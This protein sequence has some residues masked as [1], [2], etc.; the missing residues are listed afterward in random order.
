MLL[1]HFSNAPSTLPP[2]YAPP[3]RY[4]FLPCS[5]SPGESV[6]K[7]LLEGVRLPHSQA[8][9]GDIE[10]THEE[11]EERVW[12]AFSPCLYP[13]RTG[14]RGFMGKCFLMCQELVPILVNVKGVCE[15]K[16]VRRGAQARRRE[17]PRPTS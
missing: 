14:G 1:H 6:I 4:T 7:F 2:S 13:Y 15:R 17:E 9:S 16:E 11:E 5:N 3:L 8:A 10:V 12:I